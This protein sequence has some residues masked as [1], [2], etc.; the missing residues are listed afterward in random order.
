MI[1]KFYGPNEQNSWIPECMLE[2]LEDI[3]G[4]RLAL[5]FSEGFAKVPKKDNKGQYIY[6]DDMLELEHLQLLDLSISLPESLLFAI[7][8][9]IQ[10]EDLSL[11]FE[12]VFQ[13]AN[14]EKKLVKK[15]L[16][17]ILRED[18]DTKVLVGEEIGET[19]EEDE[20]PNITIKKENKK[21]F[22]VTIKNC[23]KPGFQLFELTDVQFRE[24]LATIYLVREQRMMEMVF[25]HTLHI[26]PKG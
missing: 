2:N 3:L 6:T 11:S 21:L 13:K 15:Y 25:N 9:C 4:K 22:V 20:T 8:G 19:L 18:K 1:I 23:S 17:D 5:L 24:F 7:Q 26:H 12:S 14:R 10:K 16:S